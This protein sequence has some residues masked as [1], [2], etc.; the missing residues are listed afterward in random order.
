MATA[1][2]MKCRRK[3]EIRN[4]RQII[5]KNRRPAVQGV[6]PSCGTKVFRIGKA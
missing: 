5:L 3:V 2:C 6:C 1:Y 4:P